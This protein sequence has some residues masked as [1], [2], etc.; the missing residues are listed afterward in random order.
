MRK[1]LLLGKSAKTYALAKYLSANTDVFVSFNSPAIS[2]FTTVVNFDSSDYSAIADFVQNNDISLTI[3]VDVEFITSELIN[4]FDEK[5][6]QLFSPAFNISEL[7]NDKV[8]VKKLL[9]KLHVPVPR[10]ASFEKASVAYDYLKNAKFPI[11]IKSGISE[12]ATICVNEKIA[13]SAIDD[14]VLRNETILIEEFL[15]GKTFTIY[16]VS[17]GYRALPIGNSLNYNFALDGDG[18]LLTNGVGSCSPFYKLTDAHIDYLTSGVANQVLGCYEQQNKIFSGIFGLE[19]ILTPDDRIFVNNIK[20]FIS[21]I[22][23]ASILN[24]IDID[25]IKIIDDCN[26]G[27]FADTYEFIPQKDEYAVSAMLSSRQEGQIISGLNSL[28]EQTIVTFYN[29]KKNKYLEYE[30]VKGKN[31]I[32]TTVAGTIS[33]AREKLYTEI[34]DVNFTGKTYRKDIGAM[35]SQ[36]RGLLV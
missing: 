30:T 33:R 2:E 31:I 35:M 28:D 9:Y 19:C 14:L 8:A 18:G 6:L 26:M 12:Y 1:I 3:P 17:D 36:N 34:E 27:I 32:L 10:F 7:V 29:L 21:D 16:Y 25:L 11:I 24:L 23:I 13:K 5:K 20:Y 4:T 22:D 15:Y